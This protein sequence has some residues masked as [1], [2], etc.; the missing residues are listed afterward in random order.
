MAMTIL[1]ENDEE[2]IVFLSD[3]GGMIDA[4]VRANTQQDFETAALSFGIYREVVDAEAN[5]TH[6]VT[7]P[8]VNVSEMGPVVITE[9]QYDEE[10]NEITAPVMDNRYHVNLRIAGEALKVIDANGLERWKNMGIAWTQMGT[11]DNTPN[12][13]EQAVILQNV[14]LI[15]PETISTPKRVWL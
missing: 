5:T 6:L 8:G 9:G 3:S 2:V 10:G 15:D 12:K 1:N 13:N 4:I 11:P 7:N 14:S